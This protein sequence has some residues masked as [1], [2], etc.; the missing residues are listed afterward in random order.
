MENIQK[1]NS[2][3][4]IVEYITSKTKMKDKRAY[5]SLLFINKYII[6]DML[7]QQVA[8]YSD[9]VEAIENLDWLFILNQDESNTHLVSVKK[10]EKYLENKFKVWSQTF[11]KELVADIRENFTN[12]GLYD[13]LKESKDTDK[14]IR[15]L[16]TCNFTINDIFEIYSRINFPDRQKNDFFTPLDLCNL[17]SKIAIANNKKENIKICDITCGVGNMLY[18]TYKELK[19]DNPD[20]N[21]S[22]YGIDFEISYVSFT[23]SIFHLFTNDVNIA[24]CNALTNDPFNG[25]KMDIFVGNPPFGRIDEETYT[26]LLKQENPANLIGSQKEKLDE[27]C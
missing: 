23:R 1:N 21:I 10:T 15:F 11:P 8:S 22:V 12:I 16:D 9:D 4:K 6:K 17:T 3:N 2:V 20:S 27:A 25:V 5:M 24:C 13:V 14:F 19:N 26:H 7:L 18:T